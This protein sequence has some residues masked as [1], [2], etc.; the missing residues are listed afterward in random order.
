MPN[1]YRD[2]Y[3]GEGYVRGYDR[4]FDRRPV[5]YRG[6]GPKNY[7]RSDERIFE[8]VCEALKDDHRV[9]AS[10]I[11]VNVNAGVVTLSGSIDD[12]MT[13]RRAEDIAEACPGVKDVRNEIRVS[14]E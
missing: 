8:D 3:E 14:R 6:K 9:D 12:R 10:N 1:D 2:R 11:D 7:Q 5:S 4:D 13:K